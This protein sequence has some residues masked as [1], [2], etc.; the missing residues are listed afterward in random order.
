[1]AVLTIVRVGIAGADGPGPDPS[2]PAPMTLAQ[3]AAAPATII[4]CFGGT[5]SAQCTQSSPTQP[6]CEF[7]MAYNCGKAGYS[8]DA[9]KG[10]CRCNT[11]AADGGQPQPSQ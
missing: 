10:V 4:C 3:T 1:M 2:G 5:A 7:V 11:S 9:A 6:G 8:C